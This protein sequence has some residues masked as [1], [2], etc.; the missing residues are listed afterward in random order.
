[1]IGFI[2]TSV[3]ISLNYNQYSAIADLH[4]FQFIV[5]HTLGFS[6]STCRL[7]ATDL[8]TEIIT[9]NHSEVFL[10]FLVQSSWN[11]G[12]QL[13][14]AWVWVL[15]YDRRSVGTHLGLTTRS[16]LVSDSCGLVDVWRSL[17]LTRGRVCR[18]QLLPALASAVILGSKSRGTRDHILPSQ[19]R[20]FPFRRLLRLV[21]LR[22]RYSTP[23]PHWITTTFWIRF[24]CNHCA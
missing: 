20:D 24:S 7:L 2:S 8:N 10:P 5:A 9:S 19:I 1:M 23:S 18:L 14:L 21:G 11:L 6:V 3:T 12:T 16:L 22:W 13:L 4:T 15:C 17:S